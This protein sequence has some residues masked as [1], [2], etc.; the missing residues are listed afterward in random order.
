MTGKEQA[1]ERTGFVGTANEVVKL[2]LAG[3][4]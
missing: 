4:I 1:V 3:P 2:L